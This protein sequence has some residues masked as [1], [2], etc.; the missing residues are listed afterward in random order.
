[1]SKTALSPFDCVRVGDQ[2][3]LRANPAVVCGK[4]VDVALGVVG[5]AVYSVGFPLLCWVVTRR[6]HLAT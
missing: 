5:T 2:W 6:V 1:M 4:S 3:L